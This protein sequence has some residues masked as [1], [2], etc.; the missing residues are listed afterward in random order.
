[1][2]RAVPSRSA[3]KRFARLPV[4]V[5]V[6]S[7]RVSGLGASKEALG[8]R[9]GLEVAAIAVIRGLPPRR[10]PVPPVPRRRRAGPSPQPAVCVAGLTLEA[11]VLRSAGGVSLVVPRKSVA[12]EQSTEVAALYRHP[13]YGAAVRADVLDGDPDAGSANVSTG[14]SGGG[15]AVGLVRLG[16]VYAVKPHRDGPDR[17][18]TDV[19]RIAVGDG[20]HA[21]SERLSR[22]DGLGLDAGHDSEKQSGEKQAGWVHERDC[23]A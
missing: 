14:G 1:M 11:G 16:G 4:P 2:G 21:S 7:V 9:L 23:R 18:P 19:E 10:P 12:D 6:Q 22:R 5:A 8:L 13:G 20:R 17:R 3:G 15:R